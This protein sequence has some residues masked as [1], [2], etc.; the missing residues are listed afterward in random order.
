MLI[1]TLLYLGLMNSHLLD[2]FIFA[3]FVIL[4]IRIWQDKLEYYNYVDKVMTGYL[5]IRVVLLIGLFLVKAGHSLLFLGVV[6]TL[7][8]AVLT[9][10]II[11]VSG[12]IYKRGIKEGH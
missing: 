6:R 3:L 10:P 9:W 8:A 5:I 4:T 2:I 1:Y 7:S 11:A 12:K